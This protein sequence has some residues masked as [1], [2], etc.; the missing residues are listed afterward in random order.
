V[1]IQ[2]GALA[3]RYDWTSQREAASTDNA[4]PR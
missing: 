1:E 4:P 3:G 2:G